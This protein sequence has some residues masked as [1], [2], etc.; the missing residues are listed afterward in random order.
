MQFKSLSHM[1]VHMS[2]PVKRI[3]SSRVISVQEHQTLYEA[4]E[5]M[6]QF[7][8]RHLPVVERKT[9]K[10]NGLLSEG[11]ILLHCNRRG[12]K[13]LVS[14]KILV[15]DV[16]SRDVVFC[17]PSSQVSNVAATMI[18]AKIDC[19]P[20]IEGENKKVIGIITTTDLLDEICINEELNGEQVRP[21]K[22]NNPN[23]RQYTP[24]KRSS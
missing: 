8:I 15:G 21:F 19:I 24:L 17:Y 10:L 11:D 5:L 6:R 3:M 23:R 1:E 7:D 16:M 20:V 18:A 14:N 13:L 12:E 22:Y 4:Y 2:K 9:K